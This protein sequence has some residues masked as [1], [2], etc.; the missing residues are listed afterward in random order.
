MVVD[1]T[2]KG[3]GIQENDENVYDIAAEVK[4]S[5]KYK[6]VDGVKF[7]EYDELGLPKNDGFNYREMIT[8]DENELDTVIEAP[9]D[10]METILRPKGF[11]NDQDKAIDEMNE[12]GK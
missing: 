9:P 4:K 3:R 7:V 8:T 11:R 10:A 2:S 6:A 12:E 5:Q 1:A